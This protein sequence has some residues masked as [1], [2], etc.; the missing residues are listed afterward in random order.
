MLG[1]D[2]LTYENLPKCSSEITVKIAILSMRPKLYSTHRLVEAAEKR[3][4]E[5]TVINTLR[6]YMNITPDNPTIHYMGRP[7]PH[8]DA[9]IPRIGAS[10]TFYGTAMVRQFE[11]M[12]VYSLNSAL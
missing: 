5:V 2:K 8:F 7:L 10:I 4:H 3:G 1:D 9:I 12:G 6:C 11:M